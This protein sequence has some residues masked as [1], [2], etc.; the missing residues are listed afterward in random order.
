MYFLPVKNYRT[1]SAIEVW[2]AGTLP[3]RPAHPIFSMHFLPYKNTS[4]IQPE[5]QPFNGTMMH[6][7]VYG[8]HKCSFPSGGISKMKSIMINCHLHS[9]HFPRAL[10]PLFWAT[11]DRLY[12]SPYILSRVEMKVENMN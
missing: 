12:I 6:T 11:V 2:L 4:L 7:A 5:K 1:W 8:I 10:A 3:R 9:T